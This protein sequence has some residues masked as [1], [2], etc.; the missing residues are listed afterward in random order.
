M[1]LPEE[2][3]P[4]VEDPRAHELRRCGACAGEARCTRVSSHIGAT[5]Y[6]HRCSACGRRFETDSLLTNIMR[7]LMAPLSIATAIALYARTGGD[8]GL[9]A[10]VML[11]LA[12]IAIYAA[13]RAIKSVRDDRQSP[14]I[15][16]RRDSGRSPSDGLNAPRS[17]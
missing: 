10:A 2:L 8:S 11:A 16:R 5:T 6:E 3:T 7:G 4:E 13:F 17:V 12:A 15:Q 1:P 9:E 14:V